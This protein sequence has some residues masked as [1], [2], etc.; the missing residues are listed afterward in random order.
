MPNP[1]IAPQ[2]R[3]EEGKIRSPLIR[4]MDG[5]REMGLL[6]IN[7]FIHTF[8]D[9]TLIHGTKTNAPKIVPNKK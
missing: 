7:A 3:E 6:F 9:A 4:L 2:S 5:P 1:E 8:R